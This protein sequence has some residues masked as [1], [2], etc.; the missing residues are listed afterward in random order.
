M[1]SASRRPADVMNLIKRRFHLE[2][3]DGKKMNIDEI[4]S[5]G[6]FVYDKKLTKKDYFQE[7]NFTHFAE[8]LMIEI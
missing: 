8:D 2:M 6:L 7:E 1:H 4:K 5:L 3:S